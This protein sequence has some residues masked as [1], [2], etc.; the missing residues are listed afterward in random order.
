MDH[1]PQCNTKTLKGLED[2]IGKDLHGFGFVSRDWKA[3]PS[4]GRCTGKDTSDKELLSKIYTELLKF[5]N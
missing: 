1:R 2:T 5:N 3:S 4:L